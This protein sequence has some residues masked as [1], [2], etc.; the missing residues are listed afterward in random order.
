M[1]QDNTKDVLINVMYTGDYTTENIGHEIIN[2]YKTDKGENYIYISPWGKVAD[3][4]RDKIKEVIFARGAGKGK[5]EIIGKA[6][7][8]EYWGN[9]KIDVNQSAII[10]LLKKEN[11]DCGKKFDTFAYSDCEKL[12]KYKYNKIKEKI[13]FDIKQKAKEQNVEINLHNKSKNADKNTKVYELL[14][15][16]ES[17]IE[18][19]YFIPQDSCLRDL[20]LKYIESKDIK[21]GGILL[22]KIFEQN[23]DVE[24]PIYLTYYSTKVTKPLTHIIID[25][26]NKHKKIFNKKLRNECCLSYV[27]SEQLKQIPEYKNAE[28]EDTQNLKESEYK[29]YTQIFLD[30]IGKS[31]DE[32]VFSNM[33]AYFLEKD[34]ELFRKFCN[35]CLKL[36][37]DIKTNKTYEITREVKVN[38]GRIDILIKT[39]DSIFVI[40]NKIKSGIN[41]QKYDPQ[42]KEYSNQLIAYYNHF[43][44]DKIKEKDLKGIN[45]QYYYIF[46]PN[47]NK[48]NKNEI[49]K[50][51]SNNV[52]NKEI[53]EKYKIIN[54]KELKEFFENH[55]PDNLT[56]QEDFY[57]N[58][59]VKA[60]AIHSEEND[61]EIERI[62][63]YKFRKAIECA[64]TNETLL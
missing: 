35:K 49:T 45:H 46:T 55:K 26:G 42:T 31:Y 44:E 5:L 40:E 19:E 20:Q 1:T 18:D 17:R 25:Y 16:Y 28:W 41:G 10:E 51:Y 12:I 3:N 38:D 52:Y 57:F 37:C 60:L 58:E 24:T 21:F 14:K 9:S 61:N 29:D 15:E 13:Q 2:L 36:K 48:I 53:I 43:Q 59:F 30:I 6:S 63:E 11:I 8:L 56:E 22:H 34:K 27:S 23:Y 33:I 39:D 47:Y 4:K 7:G 50:Q 54:Y 62:M 32:L 64:I